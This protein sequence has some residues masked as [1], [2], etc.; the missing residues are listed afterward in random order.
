MWRIRTRVEED[1]R[2]KVPN[3]TRSLP[4]TE[5]QMEEEAEE[6]P[7]LLIAEFAMPRYHLQQLHQ[8]DNYA[9]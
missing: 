1:G 7:N 5:F 8:A 9:F 3:T 4:L 6:L 2:L